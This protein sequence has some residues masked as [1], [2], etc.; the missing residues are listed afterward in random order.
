[1]PWRETQAEFA[2]ALREPD[3]PVPAGI[4]LTAGA[5]SQKRFGVYRNNVALSLIEAIADGYPVVKQ[6]V[7]DEFFTAMARTYV[8]ANAPQSPVLLDYGADFAEFI[9]GFEPASGLPFLADVARVEWAW[10]CAYHAADHPPA[11]MTALEALTPSKIEQACLNLHPSFNLVTSDWPA[12]SI[13]HLH[14]T[15]EDPAA[16]MQHLTPQAE[17]A[18]IVRPSYDVDVRLIP[19][20]MAGVVAAL[21]DG[22]PL[23]R[24]AAVLPEADQTQLGQLLHLLFSSG[25]I[26]GVTLAGTDK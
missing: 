17:A 14:Q 13:W 3:L 20:A 26:A 18:I 21:R 22:A 8:A 4:A 10:Q 6:L 2:G 9:A 15:S 7:G 23:G 16:E 1:M 11:T 25:A 19:P 24:A 12:V 5:P